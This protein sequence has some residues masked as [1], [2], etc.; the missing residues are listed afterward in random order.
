MRAI[1]YTG[2]TGAMVPFLFI[3]AI[4]SHQPVPSRPI[5]R[6]KVVPHLS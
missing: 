6:L 4:T 3:R 1:M 2:L 5:T